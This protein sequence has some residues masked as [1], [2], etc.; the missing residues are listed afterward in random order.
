MEEVRRYGRDVEPLDEAGDDE[1][2]F[3][4][5]M[6][7]P[8]AVACDFPHPDGSNQRDELAVLIRSPLTRFRTRTASVSPTISGLNRMVDDRIVDP[9][10]GNRVAADGFGASIDP[11]PP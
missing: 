10:Q 5:G 6:C 3:H 9:G 7:E 11:E 4:L 2:Q 1:R 8:D